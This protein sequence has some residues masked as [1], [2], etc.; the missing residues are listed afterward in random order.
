[1]NIPQNLTPLSASLLRPA[2]TDSFTRAARQLGVEIPAGVNAANPGAMNALLA[3]LTTALWGTNPLDAALL[4][5]SDS[6]RELGRGKAGRGVKAA[7][8]LA[9]DFPR[10]FGR[11][12]RWSEWVFASEWSQ[13]QLLQVM[14]EIEPMVIEALSWINLSAMAAAGSYARLGDLIA[15]F[16]KNEAQAHALRLGLTSGLETPDSQLIQALSAGVAPEKLRSSFGHMGVVEPYEIALP[17]VA[18]LAED[19]VGTKAPPEPMTWDIFRARERRET[20]MQTAFGRVGF[21]GRSELKK[22][23]QLTQ[24]TLV[25]HAKARD[26][27]AHVLAATRHW[28]QAAAAEGISDGRLAHRDEIFLL[29]IE[30]IKQMMTGEWHS[31][32]HVAPLIAQR[33]QARDRQPAAASNASRPLGVAGDKTQGRLLVLHSPNAPDA[34]SGYIALA[35]RWTPAW[36]RAL[37]MAEGVIAR[38]G[39]LL[40]WIASVARAGDL[41]AL[42]GGAIDADWPS[43]VT[44]TLDPARNRL[45]KAD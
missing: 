42:V 18:E 7:Q 45:K 5:G 27:L 33:R 4:L 32:D 19:L 31:R 14:E 20:A 6:P 26:A 12:K 38:D 13:A 8:F 40:G 10:T 1:M 44:V 23:V 39:D 30:E 37:L 28:A 35:T 15:K 9:Q 21:L 3:G 11:M 2:L 43:G 41:P 22:M 29:E 25:I 16:E 34:P 36:H 17:R 24:V